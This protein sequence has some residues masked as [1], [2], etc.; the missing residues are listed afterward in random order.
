MTKKDFAC[1]III[2]TILALFLEENKEKIIQSN[3][4]NLVNY[5]KAKDLWSCDINSNNFNKKLNKLKLINAQISQI[6]GLYNAL[7]WGYWRELL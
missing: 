2:F 6:I 1:T 7:W 5:L 3:Y 4:N